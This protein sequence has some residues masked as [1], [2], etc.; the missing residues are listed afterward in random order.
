ME[1][2]MLTNKVRAIAAVA[3]TAVALTA[4]S[5]S[6]ADARSYRRHNN[7]AA[8][9]AFMGIAGTIAALAARDRY[10]RGYYGGGYYGGPAYGYGGP[11][12][13]GFRGGGWHRHGGFR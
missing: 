9:A 8:M 11:V 2:L 3:V 7:A 1:G 12:Y 13:G 5:F 10:D 6:P 4:A